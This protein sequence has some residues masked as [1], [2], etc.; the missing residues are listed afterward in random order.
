M[1]EYSL[2][3]EGSTSAVLIGAGHFSVDLAGT[4]SA[5]VT[6]QRAAQNTDGSAP[7]D[8][9]YMDVTEA[10]YTEPISKTGLSGAPYWYRW[11]IKTGNYTSGTV[12]AHI[13]QVTP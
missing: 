9:E 10:E 4:F 11:T 3:A 7:V 12:A 8:A 1:P 5:T 13:R 2:E 6:L